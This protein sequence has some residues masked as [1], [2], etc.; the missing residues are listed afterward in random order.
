MGKQKTRQFAAMKRMLKATD[1]RLKK[2]K[3]NAQVASLKKAAGPNG[4]VVREV[5][6]AASHLYFKHNT[7]LG[8]PYH[9]IVDTN[10]I[11]FI[12]QNK[13]E[14]VSAMMDCLL[15]KVIPCITDCVMAELEKMGTK[16]RLALRIAK[17]PRFRRLTCSHRGTY[18]DDCIV[19]RC[20]AVRFLEIPLNLTGVSSTSAISWLLATKT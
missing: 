12:L 8:P 5:Q 20:N 2:K 19:D 6:K 17:D 7:A 13:L 15:A 4:E 16:Y 1:P 10:F 3:E 14:L 11:N 9:V 18:A